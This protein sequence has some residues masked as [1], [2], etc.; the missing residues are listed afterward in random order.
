[1]YIEAQVLCGLVRQLS[2][3]ETIH[4]CRAMRRL[5]T[6]EV[7]KDMLLELIDAANQAPSGSNSQRAR[8]IV[9]KDPAQKKKL[10]DLNRLHAE[11]YIAPSLEN[12]DNPVQKR[13]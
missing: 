13:I 8:W 2:L 3:S 10:A 4:N 6:R 11:P 7:P 12:P 9:V 1:M 5:E